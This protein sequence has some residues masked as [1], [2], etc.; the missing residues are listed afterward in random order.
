MRTKLFFIIYLQT[1][2]RRH[3]HGQNHGKIGLLFHPIEH[4]SRPLGSVY[5]SK[6]YTG[7]TWKMC[8]TF[9]ISFTYLT[10][11]DFEISSTQ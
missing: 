3:F 9:G 5:K 2:I 1:H 11:L 8:A 6:N 7:Y 10:L 4:N